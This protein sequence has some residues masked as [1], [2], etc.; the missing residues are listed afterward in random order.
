MKIWDSVYVCTTKPI[1][2]WTLFFWP[3][4]GCAWWW[5]SCRLQHPDPD[6]LTWTMRNRSTCHIILMD[7]NQMKM[8]QSQGQLKEMISLVRLSKFSNVLLP[9]FCSLFFWYR[10]FYPKKVIQKNLYTNKWHENI[11][12]KFYPKFYYRKCRAFVVTST[13]NQRIIHL[14]NIIKILNK[15]I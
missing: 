11:I 14:F 12:Q 4:L 5:M 1:L 6:L 15:Y 8:I 10:K 2:N 7:E 9:S 13:Q 3:E